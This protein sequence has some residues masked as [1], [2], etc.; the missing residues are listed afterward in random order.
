MSYVL[1]RMIGGED[2]VFFIYFLRGEGGLW[3]LVSM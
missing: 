2:R 1:N 3:R